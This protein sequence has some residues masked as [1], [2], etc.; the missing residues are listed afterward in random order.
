[1]PDD[2]VERSDGWI[3][4]TDPSYGIDSDYEGHKAPSEIGACHVYRVAPETGEVRIAADGFLRPNGLAFSADERQLYIVDTRKKHIRLFDVASDGVLSGGGYSPPATRDPSTA[5][6]STTP[7]GSGPPP[8]MGSTAS[9]RTAPCSASCTSRRWSPTSPSA[10]PNATTCSS[11]PPARCIA[12]ASTPPAPATRPLLSD[13][14]RSGP[15]GA[16]AAGATE[17]SFPYALGDHPD[18]AGACI[19]RPVHEFRPLTHA[20]R[21]YMVNHTCAAH[22]YGRCAGRW[23][24]W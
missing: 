12:C 6:G 11:P 21:M 2:G 16:P 22:V 10:A 23:R 13:A 14:K 15:A 5:S 19:R 17:Y 18:P 1:R 3:W 9:T 7:A 24:A 20:R 4:F 8:T